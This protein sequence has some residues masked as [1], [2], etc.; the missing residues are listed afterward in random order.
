MRHRSKRYNHARDKLVVLRVWVQAGVLGLFGRFGLHLVPQTLGHEGTGSSTVI[1]LVGVGPCGRTPELPSRFSRPP[2][3]GPRVIKRVT[4]CLIK[5]A[6]GQQHVKEGLLVCMGVKWTPLPVFCAG[7]RAWGGVLDPFT[8]LPKL[9]FLVPCIRAIT[10]KASLRV[11]QGTYKDET[12]N[13]CAGR[14]TRATRVWASR[15]LGEGLPRLPQRG[16]IPRA[17]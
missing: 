17:L 12:L 9:V 11:Q 5:A 7:R 4:S 14:A 6:R 2:L 8:F 1:R 3:G 10:T 15:V 13:A 16:A